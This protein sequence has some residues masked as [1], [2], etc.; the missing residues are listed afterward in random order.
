MNAIFN[1]LVKLL[2]IIAMLIV[3]TGSLWVFQLMLIEFINI[4]YVEI[5]KKMIRNFKNDRT[6]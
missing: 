2:W 6:R 1:F 5:L 4:D 3:I